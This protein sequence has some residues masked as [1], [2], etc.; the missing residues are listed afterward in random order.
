MIWSEM[1]AS[2]E[3]PYP[4]ATVATGLSELWSQR[5]ATREEATTSVMSV[6]ENRSRW[7]IVNTDTG[8]TVQ[9]EDLERG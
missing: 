3:S 2:D 1:M 5:F 8:E 9:F 4:W 6:G 7:W